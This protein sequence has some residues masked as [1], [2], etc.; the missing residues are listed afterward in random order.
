MAKIIYVP[1]WLYTHLKEQGLTVHDMEKP[2]SSTILSKV[3]VINYHRSQDEFFKLLHQAAEDGR[4][5]WSSRDAVMY[6]Q[7]SD[8]LPEL[9]MA[10]ASRGAKGEVVCWN[11]LLSSVDSP[12]AARFFFEMCQNGDDVIVIGVSADSNAEIL[13]HSQEL[14]NCTGDK[15]TSIL[16]NVLC[17]SH[18]CLRLVGSTD[19]STVFRENPYVSQLYVKSIMLAS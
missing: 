12:S 2:I 1:E 16:W 13:R 15:P 19:K 8:E 5:G 6:H 9:A 4:V 3:D 17:V 7:Y 14:E 10:K 11:T 18:G